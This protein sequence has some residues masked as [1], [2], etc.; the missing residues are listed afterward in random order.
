[1]AQYHPPLRDFQFIYQELFD[2][3]RMQALPGC[4]EFDGELV[5]AV[6]EEAGKFFAEVLFPLNR[7][8][9][10]E[11]CSFADGEVKT[12]PWLWWQSR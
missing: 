3:A 6:L 12:Q 5:S 10:E 11:G 4:E 7:S 1:M 2:P 9:D 8:G